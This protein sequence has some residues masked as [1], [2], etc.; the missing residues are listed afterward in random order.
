MVH[1]KMFDCQKGQKGHKTSTQRDNQTNQTNNFIFH[2]DH[3]T[4]VSKPDHP[5]F[6][7]SGSVSI[8]LLRV[9]SQT[10]VHLLQS[11]LRKQKKV[12]R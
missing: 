2:L 11:K 8:S 9:G 5:T 1:S 7:D 6:G 4:N 3:P 10:R 12:G